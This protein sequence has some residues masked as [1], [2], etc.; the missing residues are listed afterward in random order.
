MAQEGTSADGNSALPVLIGML[1]RPVPLLF[2]RNSLSRLVGT[3]TSRRPEL[4]ERLGHHTMTSYAIEVDELP[5]VLLLTPD[6]AS[7]SLTAH[8]R[9][10]RVRRDV[11]IGGGF[12]SLFR[13][14]EGRGDSDGMY[15][16]RDVHIA[17][18]TEAAMCLRNALDDLDGSVI[19]DAA[20]I[21]GPSFAPLRLVLARLRSV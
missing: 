3:I 7:P 9:W 20:S 12:M 2:M 13:I 18:N 8:R 15:F 19:D 6:P 4:F 10:E 11:T 17:G 16:A 1:L 21:R 5:F 14:L